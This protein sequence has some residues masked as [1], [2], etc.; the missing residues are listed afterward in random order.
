MPVLPIESGTDAAEKV[1]AHLNTVV[2][3]ELLIVKRVI[4]ARP[5]LV[6]RILGAAAPPTKRLCRSR[7]SRA[8]SICRIATLKARPVAYDNRMYIACHKR[9]R[10]H[11]EMPSSIAQMGD[12]MGVRIIRPDADPEIS[13]NYGLSST[14]NI[15]AYHSFRPP[16]SGRRYRVVLATCLA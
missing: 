7:L 11:P 6:A 14:Y 2:E 16:Q 13:R 12:R 3:I 1:P 5:G 10:P 4:L 9:Q 8:R 15:S